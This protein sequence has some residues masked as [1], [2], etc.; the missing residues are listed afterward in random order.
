MGAKYIIE[1]GGNSVGGK[2]KLSKEVR[3]RLQRAL[4]KLS[5]II[6]VLKIKF[7]GGSNKKIMDQEQIDQI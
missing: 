3:E 4:N 2:S 6:K 5:C 1:V 7:L